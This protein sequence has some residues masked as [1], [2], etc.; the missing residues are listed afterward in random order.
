MSRP[1][2]MDRINASGADF[3]VV[4]IGA[5]KGQV[6]IQRNRARLDAP[7]I[8]Y[9]GAVINMA[10]GTV[11]RAPRWMQKTGLEWVWRIKEEPQ[12]WRRYASDGWALLCMLVTRILPLVL[13]RWRRYLF[14]PPAGRL[15]IGCKDGVCRLSLWGDWSVSNIA[16]L[17]AR[18][19]ECGAQGN[20]VE[21][22]TSHASGLDAA[23]LGL[24]A[25]V[26]GHQGW[27]KP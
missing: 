22:D 15:E 4:S 9:F 18:L 14:S 24:L 19:T 20:A 10:A 6:W 21:I 25:I 23:V 11:A 16:E 1:E 12:L 17:R 26:R 27:G 7:V 13:R 8:S 5:R 2:L 3:V